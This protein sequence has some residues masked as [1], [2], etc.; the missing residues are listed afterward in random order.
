MSIRK[1]KYPENPRYQY[2]LIF[3]KVR[4]LRNVLNSLLLPRPYALVLIKK[5]SFGSIRPMRNFCFLFDPFSTASTTSFSKNSD[6][7]HLISGSE[8]SDVSLPA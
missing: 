4:A 1:K 7:L 2:N 5:K 3:S 6:S 8:S